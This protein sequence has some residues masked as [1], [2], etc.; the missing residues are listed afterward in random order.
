MPSKNPQIFWTIAFLILGVGVWA[1]FHFSH[2]SNPASADSFLSD[3]TASQENLPLIEGQSVADVS[4]TEKS[5]THS[6]LGF[7]FSYLKD[8]NISSFGN[9]YD[10]AGETI[11]LQKD[12]GAQGLQVLVTPF[13]EDTA[14]TIAR[15]KKDLPSLNVT[16][17]VEQN[18]GAENGTQA[19]VFSS[20]N[21]LS[22]GP[23]FE[24]WFIYKK[25][26]YQVSSSQTS[27]ELFDKVISTWK[28]QE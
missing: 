1:W 21:N 18:I 11:L 27:K 14:L 12:G 5:F 8:Y 9:Y 2:G 19:V 15:V 20:T 25:Q 7:S 10:S 22:T 3:R 26:L 6:I 4:A 28:F 17:A 23:S 24:A 13:D 16:N